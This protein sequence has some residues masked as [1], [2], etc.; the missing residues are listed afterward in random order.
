MNK[1]LCLL[2]FISFQLR[3]QDMIN[4]N[5]AAINGID[6]NNMKVGFWK[7]YDLNRD[8]TVSGT[9]ADNQKF[10]DV[11]YFIG[12]KIFATQKQDSIIIFY[13]D[14]QRI[15]T[16]LSWKNRETPIVSEN[17]EPIDKAIKTKFFQSYELPAMYY[18]GLQAMSQYFSNK[19]RPEGNGLK[20]LVV[21]SVVIDIG[22]KVE[23]ATIRSSENRFL[24]EEALQLVRDMPRWQPG[25]QAGHF[26]RT[27]IDIP[28]RFGA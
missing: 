15:K 5:N 19:M 27:T 20:G 14:G 6:A 28:I 18:G 8:I 16:K 21:V 7:L 23:K 12:G 2:L 26:V 13:V 22:G 10:S 1:L 4:Y 9:V 24:N 3:A 11:S 25:F 17:G